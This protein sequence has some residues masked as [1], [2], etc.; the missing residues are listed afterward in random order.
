MNDA[1]WHYMQ[2]PVKFEG[3]SYVPAHVASTLAGELEEAEEKIE[4]LREQLRKRESEITALLEEGYDPPAPSDWRK[5]L[6][7][8]EAVT[9]AFAQHYRQSWD[10]VPVAGRHMIL[11]IADLA[12]RLDKTEVLYDSILIRLN[13]LNK[14][15]NLV[16]RAAE[17][18]FQQ[19]RNQAVGEILK[20]PFSR[21]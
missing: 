6:D 15:H 3:K 9:V 12:T 21:R 16:R 13:E 4:E 5:E 11:M 2:C 8:R 19:Y 1:D 18:M 10:T 17:V 7:E 14:P 20:D